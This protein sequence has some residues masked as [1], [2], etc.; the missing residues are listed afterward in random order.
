[1]K[2]YI[3]G[4]SNEG[5]GKF[6]ARFASLQK[7][8]EVTKGVAEKEEF[9]SGY[10]AGKLRYAVASKYLNLKSCGLNS[11]TEDGLSIVWNR[12]GDSIVRVDSDLSWVDDILKTAK[13]EKDETR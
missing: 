6:L 4:Y 9:A 8:E 10:K 7:S 13:E 11:Y 1:M 3:N 5:S 12:D 2:K